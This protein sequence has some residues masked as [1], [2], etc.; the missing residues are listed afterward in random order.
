MLWDLQTYADII[1]F[2]TTFKR[3]VYG[4]P[5]AFAVVVDK[6]G[7]SKLGF[8][9][10]L[11]H[12]KIPEFKWLFNMLRKAIGDRNEVRT[13]FTDGDACI[14]NAVKNNLPNAV[15]RLCI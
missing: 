12:E 9:A 11:R 7:K 4:L 8:A 10:V 3:N 14:I 13:I 6:A 5:L 2:D 1:V 15:H